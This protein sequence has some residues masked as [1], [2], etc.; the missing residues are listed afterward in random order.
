[1]R[2][3]VHI[4]GVAVDCLKA[5][6]TFEVNI[7]QYISC[8][9][10]NAPT[11]GAG[12][13]LKPATTFFCHIPDSPK[14]KSCGKPM[15]RNK[16]FVSLFGFITGVDRSGDRSEVEKFRVDVDNI[17][18]GGQY[19]QPAVAPKNPQNCTFIEAL[20]FPS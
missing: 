13:D 14:Y 17:T 6:A 16:C 7:E 11:E 18:F 12:G 4:T 20:Q 9:K 2:P 1:M 8:F 5:E 3:Y 19:V 10:S 15:P